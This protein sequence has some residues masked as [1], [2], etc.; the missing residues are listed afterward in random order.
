MKLENIRAKSFVCTK[1][2]IM[3]S[4]DL[5]CFKGHIPIDLMTSH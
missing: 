3:Y 4:K 5:E 1:E 2:C